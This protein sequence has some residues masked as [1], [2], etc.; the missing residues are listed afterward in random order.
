MKNGG[1]IIT[2]WVYNPMVCI[3]LCESHV[4]TLCAEW[5]HHYT[6]STL[7]SK[8]S[9]SHAE[10]QWEI[11]ILASLTAEDE[12]NHLCSVKSNNKKTI[13]DLNTKV[14]LLKAQLEEQNQLHPSCKLPR[15][16]QQPPPPTPCPDSPIM[17]VIETP[18]MTSAPHAAPLIERIASPPA[19]TPQSIEH[20][21][22][23]DLALC[24]EDNSII[25]H[26]APPMPTLS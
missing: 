10:A 19:I 18:S 9:L 8:V 22:S 25:H 1:W 23:L 16:S 7:D 15:Y 11:I 17:E 5:A 24:M 14:N 12:I 6:Y 3:I 13:N 4:C 26:G 2:Q 20:L 21:A